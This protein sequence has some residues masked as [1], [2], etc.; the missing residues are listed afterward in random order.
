[1]ILIR[2]NPSE[3]HLPAAQNLSYDPN[4][5]IAQHRN[6]AMTGEELER[7][8]KF[9]LDR[10][11]ALT[12]RIEGLTASV[13]ALARSQVES[14]ARLD[15]IA[16]SHAESDERLTAKIDSLAHVQAQSDARLT[17]KFERF[18]DLQA[19]SNVPRSS[20][21]YAAQ[22]RQTGSDSHASRF[23]ESLVT[24][25]E[26][27]RR[28]RERAGSPDARSRKVN[29]QIPSLHSQI[30]A[31]EEQIADLRKTLAESELRVAGKIEALADAQKDTDNRLKALIAVVKQYISEGRNGRSQV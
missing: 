15:R 8:I 18:L 29:G 13:E 7:A 6:Q 25:G 26:L 3:Q 21:D 30:A 20:L 23:Q 9:I 28:A 16:A 10:D 11:A 2:G 24:L 19:D 31:S 5:A 27:V 17:A 12:A 22:S 1:L 14:D 4:E